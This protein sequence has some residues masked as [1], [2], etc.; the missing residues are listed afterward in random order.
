MSGGTY[1]ILCVDDEEQILALFE[2]ALEHTE[3]TIYTA[4]DGVEALEQVRE[5]HPDLVFLDVAMPKMS[6]D[7][8]LPLIHEID[9]DISV[10]I[11][12]GRVTEDEAR[13]FL[14]KGAFD[15]FPK[16]ID[17]KHLLDVV[18]QWR[19]GREAS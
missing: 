12:S 16:P 1:K 9:P 8:A 6:G 17:L 2:R 15:F 11:V 14:A 13:E 4:R 19:F 18:E 5:H 10:I 7:E 3:Y